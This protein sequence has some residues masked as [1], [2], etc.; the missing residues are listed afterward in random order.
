MNVA[1]IQYA[2][3]WENASES[4]IKLDS[5]LSKLNP[6]TDMIVLPEMFN[7]GFSMNPSITAEDINGVTLKWMLKKSREF[8]IVGSLAFLENEKYYNRLIVASE[9]KVMASYDKQKLFGMTREEDAFT[10]GTKGLSL[11]ILG[12]KFA[13]FV[14]YDIRFPEILRN[15]NNYDVALV[16]ASWPEKR[17]AHWD[18]I[19][20]ARAIEN[21]S[22][23]IAANR[24]GY[25]GNEFKYCGHS[26]FIEPNGNIVE[27][28]IEKEE[29]IYHQLDKN[30]IHTTRER[31]PFLNDL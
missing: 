5:I 13:F 22:Y 9:G 28:C 14:C 6:N 4:L 3:I 17:I 16:V 27:L 19:L 26:Q 18:A 8:C 25:D 21:Q 7:T 23:V 20:K 10:P 15:R 2:P 29:I 11:E 12:F 31:L 1:I 30:L 24:V